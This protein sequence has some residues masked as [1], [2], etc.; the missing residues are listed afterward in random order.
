MV[1]LSV[2]LLRR[3]VGVRIERGYIMRSSQWIITGLLLLIAG[4][5]AFGQRNGKAEDALLAADEGW[6]K[7]YSAKDLEK[8]VA[9]CDEEASMLPPNAPIATGKDA[10]TKLI[11]S[12]FAI[13]DYTLSWHANKVGVAHS[14]ELGYTSGTYNFSLKDP[15]GKT[16]SDRGKYL[17]VW[18][19][20]ADGSWK[21]LFDMF[22]SDLPPSAGMPPA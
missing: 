18:K 10:L 21:V 17:T 5:A 6:M 7:V 20:E 13:P 8:S 22:S 19:K 15:S 9:F 2:D 12:A 4:S 11:G 16:I 3:E 1:T 14:G